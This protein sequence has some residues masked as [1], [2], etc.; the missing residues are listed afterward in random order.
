M[1][2]WPRRCSPRQIAAWHSPLI[3]IV[4]VEAVCILAT[5]HNIVMCV[6]KTPSVAFKLIRCRKL[7]CLFFQCSVRVYEKCIVWK[8][9][10]CFCFILIC[11][12]LTVVWGFI[13]KIK[14]HNYWWANVSKSLTTGE[15]RC[16]T[17]YKWYGISLVIPWKQTR[18]PF[19]VQLLT[20]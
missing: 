6:I 14:V 16:I 2:E 4:E 1:G 18:L 19:I 20:G 9:S 17:S 12:S 13:S 3:Q 5:C 15:Q 11:L 8:L 10:L 7:F